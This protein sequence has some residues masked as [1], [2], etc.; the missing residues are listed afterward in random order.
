MAETP[1]L[2]R[3]V[4]INKN[5]KPRVMKYV[6][7]RTPLPAD[8]EVLVKVYA[9]SV[10]PSDLLYRSG[11]F[12]IRKPM[13]HILG[14]DLAGEIM[15]VGESVEGWSV[16]DR[17]T[18]TFETLGRERNGSYAEFCTIPADELTKLPDTVDYQTAVS[19]GASFVAAWVALVNNGKIKKADRVVIYN[20]ASSVGT[21]AVQI[22]SVKGAKVI[23]ISKGDHAA[24]LREIGATVVLDDAGVD[25]IRQV[26]VA[27]DEQGATLVLNLA[28][29]D[30]LQQSLDMLEAGGRVLLGSAQKTTEAKFNVL[31]VFLKNLSIIG[32]YDTIKLKDFETVLNN[33]G[34]GTYRAIVDEVMPLSQ[35]RQAH[36]KVEKKTTFG[37][38]I[39]VPDSILEADKKPANWIPID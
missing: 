24:R 23:A 19:A 25:I 36:E 14:S 33:L 18:A 30:L 37:K 22:A 27:T 38:V 11:R 32:A 29:T 35:A 7:F 31:D 12:I 21:A 28:D 3:A 20:A 15:E 4:A 16:G 5:G 13:P 39:L 6:D 17:V 10:N 2:M 34:K 26:K 1:E 9:T 8:D